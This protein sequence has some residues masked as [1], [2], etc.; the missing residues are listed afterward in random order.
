MQ[1]HRFVPAAERAIQIFA[2]LFG[3]VF[4]VSGVIYLYLGRVTF[5]WTGDLWDIYAFAWDHTWL[6]SALLKQDVHVKFF[7]RCV[8]LANLRFFKG[9]PQMLFFAGLGLLFVTAL[10]LLIPIWRDET[11]SLTAKSLSTLVVL[12]GNFWAARATIT[13]NGEFNCEDSLAMGGAALA[14]VVIANARCSWT[15]TAIVV[16]A[17]FLAS[18]SFGTGLAIWPTL[19]LLAWCLRLPRQTLVLFGISALTAAVIYEVL[20]VLPSD[21]P[22]VSEISLGKPVGVLTEFCK[23]LGSP[24]FYTI[25]GWHGAKPLADLRQSFGIAL[26]G[27]AG[28]TLAG[29]AV[30]PRMR[31]RDLGKSGVERT[32]LSLLIFNLFALS[33]IAVGRLKSFDLG[34]FAPR[35]LF[36][37]SLFW[38]GLILL[39]IKRAEHLRWGRWPALLFPFAIAVFAWPAHYQA[40]FR[41]KN[42]QINS[43]DKDATAMINGVVDTQMAQAIPPEYKRVFEDR[44]QKAW[45]LRACRLDVFAE[46]LQDWIG[47][48]EADVFGARHKR[49]GI[50]GQCRI[51]GS[52]QCDNG[53][54]AARVSGQAFKREQ[55]IPSTLVIVDQNGVIC[56][57]ARS[58]RISPVVNRT[59][60]QG[61]FAANVG[62]VGYIRDYNPELRYAVRSADNLTLSDEEIPVRP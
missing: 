32:G 54:P 34:P 35:Y 42:A 31:R 47:H 4:L 46:G 57:V 24:V 56:G 25:A 41:C 14:F 33:L 60:Y 2:I 37:S 50:R 62:F 29:V 16:F 26:S 39:G 59:F 44:L 13:A 10:L 12:L 55:S 11:V 51:D 38:T 45:Q 61:K 5:L 27:V 40:W 36:W 30:I 9:D 15:T 23:L 58:A 20:P 49:E 17:G 53:A 21:A 19:L 43:Y 6:E 3:A 28:L 1:M 8:C 7:P 22:K 18:F 52:G 48:S